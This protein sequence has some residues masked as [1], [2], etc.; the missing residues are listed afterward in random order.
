V[1]CAFYE[2]L[3]AKD[4]LPAMVRLTLTRKTAAIALSMW[5][6]RRNI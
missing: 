2:G 1:L 4:M 3:L 6:T 5:T